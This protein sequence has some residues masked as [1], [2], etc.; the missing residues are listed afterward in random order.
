VRAIPLLNS[1]G[2][3]TRWQVAFLQEAERAGLSVS[4]VLLA[5]SCA[6]L[7]VGKRNVSH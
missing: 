7:Q 2:F 1:D 4:R 5:V 3:V 6:K